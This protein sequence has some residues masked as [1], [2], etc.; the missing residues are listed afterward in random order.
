MSVE[1][2]LLLSLPQLPDMEVAGR[3]RRAAGFGLEQVLDGSRFL[4][5]IE[6]YL[7]EILN[8]QTS[9]AILLASST[10]A[11]GAKAGLEAAARES[12]H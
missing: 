12:H 4:V 8:V 3:G 6:R 9:S 2:L 1:I 5:V 11:E 7:W 10:A